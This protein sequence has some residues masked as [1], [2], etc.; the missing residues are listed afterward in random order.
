MLRVAIKLYMKII[1]QQHPFFFSVSF[2]PAPA[3]LGP[4]FV[5]S[6]P[7]IKSLIYLNIREKLVS[8]QILTYLE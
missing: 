3:L 1:T 2:L 6:L 4:S 8:Y 7:I 5:V